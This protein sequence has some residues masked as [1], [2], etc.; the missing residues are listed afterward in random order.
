MRADNFTNSVEETIFV[1]PKK[2]FPVSRREI[3]RTP[4]H[5]DQKE[6]F[7][8]ERQSSLLDASGKKNIESSKLGK[9]LVRSLTPEPTQE[10]SSKSR[11]NKENILASVDDMPIKSS[12]IKITPE[13]KSNEVKNVIP[14]GSQLLR[15][16]FNDRHRDLGQ[17]IKPSDNTILL[18]PEQDAI[19]S[20]PKPNVE[21]FLKGIL[22]KNSFLTKN[23]CLFSL[24]VFTLFLL[25]RYFKITNIAFEECYSIW[26]LS[27]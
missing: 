12:V 19:P 23:V 22:K 1:S 27:P 15:T 8:T 13:R 4:V 7:K 6:T 26:K 21:N 24:N 16:P 18:S 9:A 3:P 17:N 2:D 14:T 25:F 5:L 11:L 20:E 10:Q